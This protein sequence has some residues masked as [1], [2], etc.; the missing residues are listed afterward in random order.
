MVSPV[1]LRQTAVMGRDGEVRALV[2]PPA[3]SAWVAGVAILVAKIALSTPRLGEATPLVAITWLVTLSLVVVGIALLHS[4]IPRI[5]GWACLLLAAATIPSD[6]NERAYADSRLSVVGYVLE[7][8]YLPAAVALILRY[9][10][11]RMTRGARWLLGA[12]VAACIGPRIPAVLTAGRLPDGAYLP[13]GWP[14]GWAPLLHDWVSVRLGRIAVTVLLLLI[15]VTLIRRALH[16]TGLARQSITPLIVVGTVCAGAAAVDQFTWVVGWGGRTVIPPMIRDIS[17][18]MLP[19]TLLADLLRRRSAIAAIPAGVMA[20]FVG[21]DPRAREESLQRLLVDPSLR[22]IPAADA[23]GPG[24]CRGQRLVVTRDPGDAVVID[25]ST[26]ALQDESIVDAAATAVAL[27][28]DNLTLTHELEATLSEVEASRARIVTAMMDG[29]RQV[30]RDLHDGAQQ[31]FLGVAAKLARADVVE[32]DQLRDVVDEARDAF[33][34]ALAT[35]RDF[36]RG[37]HPQTLARG[38]L[39]IALPS[40][41]EHAPYR[42]DLH[43]DPRLDDGT[44]DPSVQLGVFYVISEA[45]ANATRYARPSH[46]TVRVQ[47]QGARVVTTV[48]D[49]GVGMAGA[50]PTGGLR[51]QDDRIRAL[52]GTFRLHSDP[53][54]QHPTDH[55]TTLYAELPWTSPALE[56]LE[57]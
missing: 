44:L 13:R 3:A 18:A 4:G 40:L 21:P 55:G 34:D 5:N 42:V 52:G 49:D 8:V 37:V 39:A 36:A 29:R 46:V 50:V 43:L 56:R 32:D 38:G 51:N 27:C 9:P 12:F 16:A 54:P 17:A 45:L 30:Q 10:R 26:R 53:C 7:L 28:T 57:P 24:P 23:A 6:L 35:L 48:R 33:T 11:D 22:L 20:A 1:G 2:A 47:R 31:Q 14:R 41:W 25:Y 19:F 15:C